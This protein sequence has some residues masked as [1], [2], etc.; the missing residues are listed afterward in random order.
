[1]KLKIDNDQIAGEFFEDTFLLGIM[2][3]VEAHQFVWNLNQGLRFDFRL[4]D[5]LE[6]QLT[7]KKRDYF[8]SVYT[9]REPHRALDYYL[10]KNLFDGEYLLPE[11]RH[12]DYL[13]LAKG[14]LPTREGEEQL[15][16]DL[17]RLP[18]VQL[19]VELTP[20]KIRNK[21]HLVL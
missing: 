11:F 6:I 5:E 12:L 19:V 14:D 2:A 10:Y 1:M 18:G 15:M 9:Y 17:R 7:K 4:S 3:P 21:Q 20:D 8:F 13:F 16:S